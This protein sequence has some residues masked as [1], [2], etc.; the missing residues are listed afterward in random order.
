M[1]FLESGFG[2]T[3]VLDR[4]H[5]FLYL[6]PTGRLI[7]SRI[8]KET[9]SRKAEHLVTLLIEQWFI[10]PVIVGNLGFVC[11]GYDDV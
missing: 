5:L 11:F 10:D 2:S 7:A 4:K 1:T 3:F 9:A 8:K 6:H